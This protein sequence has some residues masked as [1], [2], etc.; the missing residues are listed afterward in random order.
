MSREV[1]SN[2]SK[3]L[4]SEIHNKLTQ[5]VG[6]HKQARYQE[7]ELLYREVLAL[8]ADNFHA[9][10]LSGCISRELKNYTKALE[11]LN[12]AVKVQPGNPDAQYN[13]GNIYRDMKDWR[14]AISQYEK[15][16]GLSPGNVDALNNIGLCYNEIGLCKKAEEVLIHALTLRSDCEEAWL[17]LSWSLKSQ[18]RPE[19]A[20]VCLEKVL[21]KNERSSQALFAYGVLKSEQNDIQLAISSLSRAIELDESHTEAMIL[22]SSLLLSQKDYDKALCLA[23]SALKIAPNH[24]ACNTILGWLYIRASK[25]EEAIEFYSQKINQCPQATDNYFFLFKVLSKDLAKKI[26]SQFSYNKTF[27]R[28]TLELLGVEQIL[29]FGD[30]H[31]RMFD[32][33][34]GIEVNHVGA[35]T[36]YNLLKNDSS[37]GGRK[38]VLNR[39]RESDPLTDAVLLCFGEV[40]IRANIVRMCYKKGL[41]IEQSVQAVAERY[42]EFAQEIQSTGLKTMI[43]GGYGVGTDRNAVGTELEREFAA[44]LLHSYLEKYCRLNGII[45]FSLRELII[46]EDSG[47]TDRDFLYDDFHLFQEASARSEVQLLL[48]RE[49]Y[50]AAKATYR[51]SKNTDTSSLVIGNTCTKSPL[52]LG[53]LMGERICW[54]QQAP[55]IDSCLL[56]LGSLVRLKSFTLTFLEVLNVESL[57]ILLDGIERDKQLTVLI[58]ERSS[59]SILVEPT[60]GNFFSGRYLHLFADNNLLI[61]LSKISFK[62]MEMTLDP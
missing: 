55:Q 57:K 38:H 8:D 26:N 12:R 42:L 10:N 54:D 53:Y 3:P 59:L 61:R 49:L 40:D 62:Q 35:S 24:Q 36:A 19:E 9:L 29:A 51:R 31:V 20:A 1:G 43:Y 4:E 34:D 16:L 17:N 27:L 28:K 60:D 52:T 45:Y 48:L 22:L 47:K 5:A 11:L 32:Q 14:K 15:A 44:K 13:L 56:D 58:S 41:T 50:Q 39:L 2:D 21:N 30:S 23:K 37:T 7:A 18:G 33:I 25:S 6:H 46:D